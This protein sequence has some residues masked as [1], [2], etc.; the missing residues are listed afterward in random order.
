MDELGELPLQLQPKLLRALERREVKRVGGNKV[1][2]V[3]TRIIAATNRDLA[4]EVNAGTF[5]DDLYYRLA[6]VRV[7]VPPLCERAEDIIS[8]TLH[9]L[10]DALRHEPAYDNLSTE[11]LDAS[12]FE[13]LLSYGWPGNVRELRNVVERA[14]AMAGGKLP[15]EFRPSAL[16]RPI[17]TTA[18]PSS[19]SISIRSARLS[20]ILVIMP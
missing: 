17:Q 12:V 13:P 10:K 5:R 15:H 9:F 1:M 11:D 16:G 8:L 14:V 20:S 2:K 7:R 3:D 4:R 6:V 19:S 18:S